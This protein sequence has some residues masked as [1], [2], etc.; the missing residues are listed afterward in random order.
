[1]NKIKII[2]DPYKKENLFK[3]FDTT[4][5]L[6]IDISVENNPNS[7][8][9]SDRFHKGFFP[10]VVSDIVNVIVNEYGSDDYLSICFEG[11]DLDFEQLQNVC[12]ELHSVQ[13]ERTTRYLNNANTVLDTIITEFKQ[14][15]SILLDSEE[16]K[17][18]IVSNIDKFSDVTNNVIPLCIIG[19]YSA[20]KSTFI[21][22]LVGQ[23]ILPSGDEPVTAKVFKICELEQGGLS[24]IKFHRKD[25]V[26]ILFDDTNI[27]IINEDIVDPIFEQLHTSFTQVEDTCVNKK[28]NQAL[29][30]IN[31]FDSINTSELIEIG[32]PFCGDVWE[33]SDTKFVILDT[34]G[35]N[36]ASNNEH[37]QVLEKALEGL[38]NGLSIYVS[39]Y[40]NLDSIDNEAL[41]NIIK[42]LPQLDNRFSLIVV[43]KADEND[44]PVEGYYSPEKEDEILHHAIP[45]SLYTEGIFFVSSILGLGAK[46]GGKFHNKHLN[47]IYRRTKFTFEDPEDEDYTV[48]Y[49]YNIMPKQ[50]KQNALQS[51]SECSDLVY[52][53]SG[54]F[55]VEKEIQNFASKYTYY[56]KCQQSTMY[57][58]EM[59]QMI[60]DE[61]LQIKAQRETSKEALEEGLEKDKAVLVQLV[62]DSGEGMKQR[63]IETYNDKMN[64]F[65]QENSITF[66][67]QEME[68]LEVEYTQK[69]QA[70]LQLDEK[71]K[72][73]NA[74]FSSLKT[75]FKEGMGG[76]LKNKDLSAVKR[77]G[78]NFVEDVKETVD[79]F[80]ESRLTKKNV[81]R[82]VAKLLLENIDDK[83][84]G[85]CEDIQTQMDAYS[86]D[87]WTTCSIE[88]RQSLSKLISGS[89]TLSDDR[90]CELSSI[91]LTYQNINF[92]LEEDILVE[93]KDFVHGFQIGD[94]VLFESNTLNT[95]KLVN[96]YNEAL[97][98]YISEVKET[99]SKSHR[100]TFENWMGHLLWTIQNNIVSYNPELSIKQE[101]ID[102]EE[103][104]INELIQRQQ[105]IEHA[106]HK[107]MCEMSWQTRES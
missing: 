11:S 22:A 70:L 97:G 80:E 68:Q 60:S 106:M 101:E 84:K 48:L 36:S 89:T 5:E 4:N 8:L 16:N 45:K 39:E 12:S 96:H 2:C 44:L 95:R 54:L 71:K 19:N 67:L 47:K 20:G 10:F 53:N 87:Y 72:E 56:N 103:M 17:D 91:I 30:I 26:A 35:S 50:L 77:L 75:N 107:I 94:F 34:P 69:H 88:I 78:K 82:E 43:N 46:S 23:E 65:T 7:K 66:D 85:H 58:Q 73:V 74:S 28:I 62:Q 76:L 98:N 25:E 100:Q 29:T 81:D 102:T 86:K 59:I 32:I 3:V 61:I 105:T 90:R 104:K 6:W 31:T 37:L 63:V 14:L 41:Y 18:K 38:T 49:K 64:C 57:L 55:C 93:L 79:D 99:F 83:Y 42:D 21:N 9:L 24:Y 15:R 51:V 27:Q 33:K 52:A 92:E 1:M 13:L 40:D